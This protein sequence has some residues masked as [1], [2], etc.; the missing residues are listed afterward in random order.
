MRT[1]TFLLAFTLVLCFANLSTKGKDNKEDKKICENILSKLEVQNGKTTSELVVEAGKVLMN[2]PYVANTLEITPEQLIINLRELDCTTFAE[3]CL[4]LARTSKSTNPS[5]DTFKKELQLIR[6]RNGEIDG[7]PSRLHYFSDWIADND[8]KQLVKSVSGS[9]SNI[10]FDKTIN[11]MSHHPDSYKAIANNAVNLA[12]IDKQE[13]KLTRSEK[14]YI[15]TEKI[16]SLK[17]LLKDGDIIGITTNVEGLDITHVGIIIFKGDELHFIHASSKA[18]K[19]IISEETLYD[20]LSNRN[21]TTGIMVA[22]PL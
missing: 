21:S 22:R 3:N 12:A 16:E 19:V 11:F 15:P 7:Y 20:Y 18:E 13:K 10:K 14:Y 2:T 9:I 1:K 4:A 5:F 8:A 6:Y 17:N